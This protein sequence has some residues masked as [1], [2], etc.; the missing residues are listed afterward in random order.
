MGFAL[1]YGTPHKRRPTARITGSPN[2]MCPFYRCMKLDMYIMLTKNEAIWW[3]EEKG[4][5]H[6]RLDTLERQHPIAGPVMKA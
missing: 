5:A 6:C 1:S 2:D 4:L 3:G